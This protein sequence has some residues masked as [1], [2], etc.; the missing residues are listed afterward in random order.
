MKKSVLLFLMSLIAFYAEAQNLNHIRCAI[1]DV[2]NIVGEFTI[3]VEDIYND[4]IEID[5]S[6]V[7]YGVHTLYIQVQDAEG[8]WSHYATHFFQVAGNLQMQTLSSIEYFF[9]EDPGFGNAFA[10]FLDNSTVFEGQLDFPIPSDLSLGAHNLY[11]RTRDA[12]GQWSHTSLNKIHVAGNTQM[13]TLS[14]VEYFFDEDP[15]IGNAD[16]IT[17]S[18]I[19]EI[20]VNFDIPVPSDL[21]LGNHNLYLRCADGGNQWS[22]YSVVPVTICETYAPTASFITNRYQ[23]GYYVE[24]VN[25]S[26]LST[27]LN[28]TID[29]LSVSESDSLFHYFTEPGLYEVCLDAS[30]TCGQD[31]FCDTIVVNGISDFFAQVG[32]NTGIASVTIRGGFV[33]GADVRLVR[34]G[35]SEIIA[36]EVV[37]WNEGELRVL[38]DLRGQALGDWQL[39]VDMGDEGYF[40]AGDVYQIIEGQPAEINVELIGIRVGRAGRAEPYHLVVENFGDEDAIGIPIL[41]RQAPVSIATMLEGGRSR[42]H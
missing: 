40:I 17:T 42:N 8:R 30:N 39:S 33:P 1:D 20:D 15:G 25:N 35:Y 41:M 27:E 18:A 24:L 31:Q 10:L 2:S 16:W 37:F 9:D 7:G 11:V 28:W 14:K 23:G 29:G 3:N 13:A 26:Q 22:H 21:S 38:F 32:N 19:S 36:T 34:D 12:G 6:T 5:L 4:V